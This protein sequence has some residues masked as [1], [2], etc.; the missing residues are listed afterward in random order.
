[1]QREAGNAEWPRSAGGLYQSGQS[2]LGRTR[3]GK[4]ST[5][6]EISVKWH[7]MYV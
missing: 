3:G 7:L 6:A 5:M 2:R 1:M 4:E